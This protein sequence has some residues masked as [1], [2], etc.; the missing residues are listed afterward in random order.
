MSTTLVIQIVTD[1]SLHTARS[2]IRFEI[3]EQVGF[4]VQG[5]ESVP[6]EILLAGQG[7]ALGLHRDHSQRFE[8][9]EAKKS[10]RRGGVRPGARLL[11]QSF[12]ATGL[13]SR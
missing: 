1:T 5:V 6:P 4:V 8:P 3:F 7:R 10:D 2:G 13:Q 9:G 11:L 12:R